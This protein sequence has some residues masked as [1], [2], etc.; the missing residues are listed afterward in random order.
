M[1]F[2]H[3]IKPFMNAPL[4]RPV[5]LDMLKGYKRPNDK[6]SELIKSGELIQLKKGVYVPGGNSDVA[7]PELFVIANHLWGPSYI[8]LDSAMSFW[9]LI[10]ERVYEVSSM[11]LKLSKNYKTP[12]G[13]FSYRFLAAPYYSFG[14]LSVELSPGQVAIVASPEK[15]LCDKIITTSS[16]ILRSTAQT[17]SFLLDDL[18]IDRGMLRQFNRKELSSWIKDAPKKESL[19][20]L[21]KTLEKI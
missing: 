6:I 17:L 7:G 3:S 13:R 10:P 9:G 11:T 12:Q 19:R 5:I 21:V 15:A 8:S 16:L 18:R 4:S 20:M 1:D 14:T 2:K